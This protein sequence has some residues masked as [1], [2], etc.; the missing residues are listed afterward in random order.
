MDRVYMEAHLRNPGFEGCPRAVSLSG[1]CGPWV[2][3]L[4]YPVLPP[5]FLGLSCFPRPV[6]INSL[7]EGMK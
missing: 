6:Q 4:S 2:R 1:L 3:Q 7:R 5:L